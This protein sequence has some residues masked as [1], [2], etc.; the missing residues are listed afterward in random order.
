VNCRYNPRNR[1]AIFA[2]RVDSTRVL[3]E[4]IARAENPPLVWM[5]ASTATI[6]RHSL[7]R[8][9]DEQTGELGG[10]EADVPETWRFSI[11]VA[12]RWEETFA[13][14]STPGTRKIA[15]RSAMMMSPDRGGV[16][17]TLLGLVRRGLGGKQGSGK[18]FVSWIHEL[19]FVSAIEFLLSDASLEGPV[20]L[21]APNPL[22]NGEFM[23]ALRKAWGISFGLP[24]AR[25]MLECGALFLQTE[26]E[27]ILKSRR[28][29]PG[30]LLQA[31]FA[32]Q[33]ASWPKA[34]EDL[35]RHW[36]TNAANHL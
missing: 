2:S 6:Y 15:L 11:E 33:F 8:E 31:G 23:D 5:N 30:R 26:T 3:G 24:C 34:A 27:L 29:V 21:A 16:F 20:N 13:E 18:Q 19:D 12:R 36:K 35:V 32:F 1:Y 14:A 10:T 7:D 4:A 28:V 17:D 22:P 9:M 25:W